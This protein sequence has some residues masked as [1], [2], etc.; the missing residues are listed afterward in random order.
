[1]T[2]TDLFTETRKNFGQRISELLVAIKVLPVTRDIPV[3]LFVLSILVRVHTHL[4]HF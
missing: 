4:K 3:L 1:M 2:I